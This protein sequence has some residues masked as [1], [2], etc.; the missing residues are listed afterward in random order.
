MVFSMGSTGFVEHMPQPPPPIKN[1]KK[2]LHY[3]NERNYIL[4]TLLSTFSHLAFSCTKL[5][6]ANSSLHYVSESTLVQIQLVKSAMLEINHHR[7]DCHPER[8]HTA[9]SPEQAFYGNCPKLGMQ[10]ILNCF[11]VRKALQL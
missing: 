2:R 3:C 11:A 7:S 8:S 10:S 5:P 9:A 6:A 1:E 4:S